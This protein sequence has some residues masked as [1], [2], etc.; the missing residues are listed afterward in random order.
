MRPLTRSKEK[1][2]A[3]VRDFDRDVRHPE[4]I[5]ARVDR[6]LEQRLTIGAYVGAACLNARRQGMMLTGS[7]VAPMSSRLCRAASEGVHWCTT[8]K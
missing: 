1:Q 2:R 3:A 7:D 8:F 5:A 6:L 4:S